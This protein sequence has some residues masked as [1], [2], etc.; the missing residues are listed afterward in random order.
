MERPYFVYLLRC[1]DNSLYTGITTDV[2]RRFEEHSGKPVGAKYTASRTPVRMERVWSCDGRSTASKLEYRI[3]TLSHVQKELLIK[4]GRQLSV[5][6]G[7]Y[8]DTTL[9]QEETV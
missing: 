3:K 4:D 9:Y 5:L 1:V 2:G 7:Q 6:L 8:I